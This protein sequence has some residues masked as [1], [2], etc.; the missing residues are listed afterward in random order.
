MET[1][2]RGTMGPSGDWAK[3]EEAAREKKSRESGE[4][5]GISLSVYALVLSTGTRTQACVTRVYPIRR[6]D[7]RRRCRAGLRFLQLKFLSSRR[8]EHVVRKTE[9]EA[10]ARAES[11]T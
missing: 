5:V 7:V 2:G 3:A 1:S 4:R 10:T 8:Q 9:V 6:N 11:A